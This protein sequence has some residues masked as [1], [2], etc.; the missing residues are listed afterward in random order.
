MQVAHV[1]VV[2][3]GAGMSGIGA[4][5]RLRTAHPRRTFAIMEA[6]AALGG[7]WDLFRFPGIRSDSDMFTLGYPFRPWTGARAIADGGAILDYL[8]ETAAE[9]GIDRHIRFDRRVTTAAWSSAEQRWSV[10]VRTADGDTEHLTCAF[11]FLCGGY[12]HYDHGYTPE[13]PGLAAFAGD[14]VHPQAW[15]ADLEVAGRRVVV[16]G[17]GATAVTL[18]PA[19]A[20]RGAH[21]TM[22]QRSPSWVVPLPAT[23]PLA[24]T[25]RRWLP[26]GLGHT[27][28]RW[29]NILF[30]QFFFQLCR[31]APALARR[32]LTAAVAHLL[33]DPATQQGDF[34]PRYD[35]WDQRPCVVPDADLFRAMRSGSAEVVTDRI[36][37]V[38][39]NGLTLA[40]GREL[41][42]DVLVTATGLRLLAWGGVAITVDGTR[43]EP[44]DTV[45]YR[46]CLVSDVPNM[47]FCIGYV[48]ASWTLRADLVARYVAR[49]LTHMDA[50]D[51]AVATPRPP[52]PLATRP[53][54]D[55]T[56]GYVRRALSALPRQGDRSPW[57][58]R[59]NYLR[60]R[61]D[62]DYGN[63]TRDMEFAAPVPAASGTA[64]S[65][66]A[67]P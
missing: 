21:V 18:V 15:P 26:A 24:D 23:D 30:T 22:L 58:L 3:V 4:A 12:Y 1:D 45:A 6:R 51:R 31:R 54:L 62:M 63:L 44:G 43:V 28:A 13:L 17:S 2:I 7:T 48:N 67:G 19:L 41:P 52:G 20:R 55:L 32:R 9:L 29:K 60:D 57:V 42:A 53:L 61:I 14:T 56:S 35:P 16:I 36:A 39:P 25:L 50:H 37:T 33:P 40:S 66:P 8:R 34:T 47:A 27:A 49:L 59:Q 11:L 5:H 38:T 64:V 65:T 46:G 10:E